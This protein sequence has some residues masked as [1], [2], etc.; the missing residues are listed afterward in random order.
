[1]AQAAARILLQ[2][3]LWKTTGV[4]L[5]RIFLV[6]MVFELPIYAVHHL[7]ANKVGNYLPFPFYDGYKSQ[8]S[9]LH[10]QLF[11]LLEA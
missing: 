7:K 1:M 4:S 5:S 11:I 2:C 10:H 3:S 8:K 9:S 6:K